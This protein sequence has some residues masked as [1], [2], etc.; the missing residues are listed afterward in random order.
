MAVRKVG[1]VGIRTKRY[2]ETIALLSECFGFVAESGAEPGA[3]RFKMV[4]GTDFEVYGPEDK[5]HRFFDSGPVVG[6][7]VD[8]FDTIRH[9]MIA[10]GVE[11]IGELQESNS[12][13]RWQHFRLPDGTVLELIGK[14]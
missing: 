1:F 5:F 10:R 4:D 12:G 3:T 2:Q 6:I 8:D 11:F 7:E 14:P 13:S 9:A